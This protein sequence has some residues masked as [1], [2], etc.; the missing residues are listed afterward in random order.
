MPGPISGEV[1]NSLAKAHLAAP[2]TVYAI[3]YLVDARSFREPPQL[4]RQILLQR[5]A[6]PLRPALESCVDL[7]GDVAYEHIRHACIMLSITAP[8][9]VKRCGIHRRRV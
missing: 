1:L 2:P 5:L 4:G 7:F 8:G 3:Q 6:V 9:N